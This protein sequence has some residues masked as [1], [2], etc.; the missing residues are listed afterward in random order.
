MQRG[1]DKS[2]KLWEVNGDDMYSDAESVT[3]IKESMAAVEH[4]EVVLIS[5]AGEVKALLSE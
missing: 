1:E 3:C 2:Y 4:G 5:S